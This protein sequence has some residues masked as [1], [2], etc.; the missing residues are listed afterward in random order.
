MKNHVASGAAVLMGIL[1]LC[2]LTGS[3]RE[4]PLVGYQKIG[5]E[6]LA[7]EARVSQSPDDADALAS[8]AQHYVDR[9]APGMAIAALSRAPESVRSNARVSHA[10]AVALMHEGKASEA[11]DQENRALSA[12]SSEPC[13][14]WMVASAL[15]HHG[16]LSALVDHGV[17]DYRRDP[18]ATLAAYGR[19]SRNL[20]AVLDPQ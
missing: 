7:L 4:A 10:W 6:I 19:V 12:C 16:F 17:E 18:D 1:G 3:H 14:P 5:P 9:D 13:A 20:V 11:L 8:L 2:M 15:R